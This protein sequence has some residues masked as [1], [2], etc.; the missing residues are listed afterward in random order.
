MQLEQ[1]VVLL[2]NIFPASQNVHDPDPDKYEPSAHFFSRQ[3]HLPPI[4][5]LKQVVVDEVSV[6]KC[7]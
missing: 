2:V 6:F 5:P 1:T 4:A 7:N 3:R